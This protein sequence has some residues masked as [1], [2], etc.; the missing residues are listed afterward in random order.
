MQQELRA[1]M[2]ADPGVAALVGP[3]IDWGSRPQ[4]EALPAICLTT[5]FGGPVDHSLDGP[6]LYRSRVQVDCFA[7]SHAGAQ[8]VGAE[9][10]RLL[11]GFSDPVLRAV[12]QA[13]GR[14][15]PFDEGPPR[16]FC[17]SIDFFIIHTSA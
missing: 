17:L 12:L 1:L 7:A 15:L 16:T 4:G 14:D 6:G 2:L 13:G 9:V 5:V 10:R 11:D 3:R 8:A